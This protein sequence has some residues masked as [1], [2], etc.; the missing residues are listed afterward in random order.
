MTVYKSDGVDVFTAAAEA[1]KTI[2]KAMENASYTNIGHGY[3][4]DLSEIIKE[5]YAQLSSSALQTII[6]VF[7]TM[8]FFV[9][10]KPSVIAAI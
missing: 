9:G 1:K 4:Q 10:L 8:L 5:D 7:L 6:L 3:T 2:E